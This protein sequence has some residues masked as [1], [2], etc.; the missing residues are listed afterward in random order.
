M[1]AAELRAASYHEAGHALATI[2]A[3]GIV[4]SIVVSVD[5]ANGCTGLTRVAVRG[6]AAT[7]L[8]RATRSLAGPCAEWRFDEGCYFGDRDYR[9]ADRA[10]AGLPCEAFAVACRT[11][12]QIVR[13]EAERIIRL[14]E[15]LR[16]V[17]RLD[18]PMILA[19]LQS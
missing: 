15:T 9:D 6:A 7:P 16:E 13:E 18:E 14:A 3:G 5:A 12:E 10:L 2:R 17:H 1:S 8:W 19:I 4:R 11:A